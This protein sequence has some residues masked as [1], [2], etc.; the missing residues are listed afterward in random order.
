MA[1]ADVTRDAVCDATRDASHVT[2]STHVHVEFVGGFEETLVFALEAE[3]DVGRDEDVA[4]VTAPR[5][6]LPVL[7]QRQGVAMDTMRHRR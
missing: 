6:P 1:P 2:R 4:P 5:E 3:R 7:K